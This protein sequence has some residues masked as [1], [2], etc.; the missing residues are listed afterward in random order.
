MNIELL[1]ETFPNLMPYEEN[2]KNKYV[3]Q[4]NNKLYEVAKS[5]I[6]VH[7]KKVLSIFLKQ[8]PEQFSMEQLWQE[9]FAQQRCEMPEKVDKFQLFKINFEKTATVIVDFQRAFEAIIGQRIYMIPLNDSSYCIL[10]I[11]AEQ[12][13]CM[14]DY[15]ALLQDDFRLKFTLMT[16]PLEDTKHLVE[17]F[18]LLKNTPVL[19]DTRGD[20]Y[21]FKIEDILESK[22]LCHFDAKENEDYCQTVLNAALT[23]PLLLE[24][25][26][27]YIENLYNF[28]KTAKDLYIHR[29]TL[30]KRLERFEKMSKRSLKDS[31]DLYKIYT[32]L[33]LM[34]MCKMYK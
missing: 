13:Y 32:A 16:T 21:V 8:L 12:F 19:R 23:E 18:E 20:N 34:T 33:K 1:F 28:S 17:R 9:F 25:I 2:A 6:T 7:E 30:Q 15:L 31:D 10:V 26:Q 14:N 3:F 4:G 27:I 29:N 22:M 5:Q 11:N 24:T